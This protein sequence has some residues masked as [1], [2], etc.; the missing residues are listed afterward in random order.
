[1]KLSERTIK[2]LG[3]ITTGDE[4][5]SPYRS[6]PM[7]IELFNEF[8]SNDVY[9]SGFPSRWVFA[10]DKL[11]ELNGTGQMKEVI[12]HVFD[13]REFM[14]TKFQPEAALEYVNK[15][16]AYDGYQVVIDK[17]R[18]RIR[19]SSGSVVEVNLPVGESQD[20]FHIFID[21][22][23]E[24]AERKIVEGDYDGAITN[25]RSLVESVLCDLERSL[26]PN[27]QDHDGD[28]LKLYRR[29][30]RLLNL[31][32]A[33]PDIDGSLKQLLS[34]LFSIVNGLAAVRNRMG[35]AHARTYK[36]S[37]HHAV[38]TVD[39]AKTIANFLYETMEFQGLRNAT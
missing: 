12:C 31:D 25:A 19:D 37:K 13:P 28:L 24:K 21:E 14:D 36:P 20:D 38:L 15:R 10:E 9:A 11:R 35:D 22:Q 26:D 6:G 7:L 3:K 34:G 18:S 8:G 29:V 39:A 2:A 16:L 33:R 5:L 1:M 4:E 23:V 27:A 32:P 17:G 30:Q